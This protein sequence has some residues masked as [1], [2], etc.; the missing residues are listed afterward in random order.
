MHQDAPAPAG[1]FSLALNSLAILTCWRYPKVAMPTFYINT[2]APLV[3]SKAG[4]AASETHGLRPFI[5]GSIR[6]EPDLEHACPSISCLCR[7][8]KFA[9]RLETGDVVAYLTKKAKFKTKVRHRRLTA[10]LQVHEVCESHKAA[11]K[12]YRKHNYA[13]PSNCMVAGN[14][15]N[16]LDRSHRHWS[17]GACVSEKQTHQE[18]DAEYKRRA[19]EHPCFVICH[20]RFLKLTWD[21]PIVTDAHL[22]N[23]F[24][25]VPSTQNPGAL[26]LRHHRKL[27]KA[28]K[29][30][31]LP[32]V[33]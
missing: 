9:P 13:L 31:V 29:I 16:S 26:E 17:G 28:L 14:M 27:M 22:V 15:A 1:V 32:S 19:K 30:P 33:Q 12:W 23:V 8:G 7:A 25:H 2:Y 10:V 21:A 6:R 3:S 11:A 18:W 24:G 20:I 4:I 5:D